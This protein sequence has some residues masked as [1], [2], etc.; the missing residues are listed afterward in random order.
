MNAKLNAAL[1]AGLIATAFVSAPS[2][3]QDRVANA[4]PSTVVHYGDLDLSS[5][6]GIHTLYERIQDA[7]RRVCLRMI[8][9]HTAHAAIENAQCRQSL[10]AVAVAEVDRPAL[11]FLDA[12]KKPDDLTARR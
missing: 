11:T 2:S 6:G 8:P 5:S 9:E 4:P 7:A 10:T 3:A 12:G 1:V